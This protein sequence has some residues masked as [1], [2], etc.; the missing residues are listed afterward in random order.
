MGNFIDRTGERYGRLTVEKRGPDKIHPCGR[1]SVQWWCKCDCGNYVLVYTSG[2]ASGKTQSCGCLQR[3][4]AKDANHTHGDSRP[5]AEYY[6][7]YH[8]WKS[9]KSRCYNPNNAEYKYYGGRGITVCDA[10]HKYDNFK[11]WAISSG[12]DVGAAFGDCTIDRIDVNGDYSPD[13]CRWADLF[14]QG[15]NKTNTIVINDCGTPM[16][17]RSFAIKHGKIPGTVRDRFLNGTELLSDYSIKKQYYTHNGETHYLREW[18]DIVGI[19][20]ETIS[21][22]I[23]NGWSVDEALTTPAGQKRGK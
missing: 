4:R 22:R 19:L 10:W 3:E 20:P 11:E 13:N 5:G 9:M 1:K 21:W 23:K 18:A 6:R 2:L 14:V 17:L 7:L 8:V 12:Y 16:S 15:A